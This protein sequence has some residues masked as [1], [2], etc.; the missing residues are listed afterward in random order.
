MQLFDIGWYYGLKGS[1]KILAF[2]N[3]RLE[4][5]FL[6]TNNAVIKRNVLPFSKVLSIDQYDFAVVHGSDKL[7]DR[8]R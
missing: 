2:C 7:M 5:N 4:T 3:K 8:R 6:L 1:L